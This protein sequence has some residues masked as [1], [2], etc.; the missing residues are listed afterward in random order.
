MVV[1]M[2]VMPSALTAIRLAQHLNVSKAGDGVRGVVKPGW[3]MTSFN[4]SN[5][6]IRSRYQNN[7]TMQC[8][9]LFTRCN[10]WRWSFLPRQRVYNFY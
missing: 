3:Y 5:K 4:L 10:V 1:L 7:Y 9:K 8:N 6:M 2:K